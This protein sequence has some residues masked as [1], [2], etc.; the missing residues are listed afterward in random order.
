MKTFL[1]QCEGDFWYQVAATPIDAI[2]L[3]AGRAYCLRNQTI[4]DSGK[5]SIGD[6]YCFI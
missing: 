3:V 5:V 4:W 1:V 6:F 2:I